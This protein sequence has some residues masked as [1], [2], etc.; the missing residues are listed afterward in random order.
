[1]KVL[2]LGGNGMVGGHSAL[3]LTELG[4]KVTLASRTAP[5][6]GTPLGSLPWIQIDYVNDPVNEAVLGAFDALVFA[7]GNDIRHV[8][9]DTPADV[10]WGRANSEA[11]P[12]FIES[13]KAAGVKRAIV[14]GSFYPQAAPELLATEPYIASRKAADDGARALADDSFHVV[15]L[16][17]P[18]IIGHVPGLLIPAYDAYARWALGQ[19]PLPRQAPPGGTNV[20]SVDTLTDAIVDALD[21]GENGRAYLIGDENLTW[22]QLLQYFLDAAGDKDPLPVVDEEFPLL[23]DSMMMRGRGSTIYFDLD[24]EQAKELGYRTNDVARTA[25]IIVEAVKSGT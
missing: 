4:H 9:E 16:N 11:V 17:A 24:L 20:I 25:N 1:M 12:A 15:S 18:V 22:A 8:P 19:L 13:A 14:I 10:H 2:I 23:P 3:R 7:A 21:R 6:T 5:A